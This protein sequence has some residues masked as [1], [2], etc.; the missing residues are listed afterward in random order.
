VSS[1]N[2][3]DMEELRSYIINFF[4]EK[5]NKYDLFIPYDDGAAHASASSKTNVLSTGHFEK[6]IY[7]KVRAPDFIFNRLGLKDYLLNADDVQRL[8]DHAKKLE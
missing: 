4:L 5:Q 2:K 7:Y 3:K 6:G 1:F 8:E